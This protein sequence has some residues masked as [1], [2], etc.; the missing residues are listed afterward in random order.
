MSLK[1]EIIDD[2]FFNSCNLSVSPK[3]PISN[4]Y[5]FNRENKIIIEK[6]K[7]F[8][9]SNSNF[10]YSLGVLKDCGGF[11]IKSLVLSLRWDVIFFWDWRIKKALYFHTISLPLLL[12]NFLLTTFALLLLLSRSFSG[13]RRW[14]LNRS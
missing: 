13:W 7:Y 5:Y 3:F 1:A 11:V 8:F 6:K 12:F 4:M 14:K 2:F 10:F 9:Y